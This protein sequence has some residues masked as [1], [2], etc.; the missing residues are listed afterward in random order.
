MKS[1]RAAAF[2]FPVVLQ[3]LVACST[4]T[5]APTAAATATATAGIGS[6]QNEVERAKQM[7]TPVPD[8]C[9][10][11]HSLR[12]CVQVKGRNK[13]EWYVDAGSPQKRAVKAIEVLWYGD[14]NERTVTSYLEKIGISAATVNRILKAA[15]VSSEQRFDD[16]AVVVEYTGFTLGLHGVVIKPKI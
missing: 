4:P 9:R 8:A 7:L 16:G 14:Q 13:I 3:A 12:R 6:W 2:V 15:A 11:E 5:S 10:D 1:P